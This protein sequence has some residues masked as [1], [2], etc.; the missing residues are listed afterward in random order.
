MDLFKVDKNKIKYTDN[1]HIDD[2][3]SDKMNREYNRI[4]K[5][6]DVL[7][8]IF[9]FWKKWIINVIPY[10]SGKNILEVS[11]GS[12]FLMS[13]YGLESDL[14]ITGIDYNKK[15]I[16]VTQKKL[17]MKKIK[18]KLLQADVESLPFEDNTFD[19]IINTMSLTGYPD[20]DM[21]VSEMR[22]VLRLNGKLLIVDFDYPEDR[23]IFGYLFVKLWEK[24]G[25]IIKDIEL[26]LK[27]HKFDCKNHT[28]GGLGSVHLYNCIKK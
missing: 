20:G 28:I 4:A 7:L 17:S 8:L 2:D 3:Y 13:Q 27:K 11:F 21:A 14:D 16:E 5:V 23:N 18:A 10:I 1:E 9:P 26:L 6:Y 22:R 24:F 19:T 15:M 12:G 25:D